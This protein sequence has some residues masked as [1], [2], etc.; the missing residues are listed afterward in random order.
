MGPEP[1]VDD[2]GCETDVAAAAADAADP[3]VMGRSRARLPFPCPACCS[4]S[5]S[6]ARVSNSETHLLLQFSIAA[7]LASMYASLLQLRIDHP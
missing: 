6:Y 4:K 2:T 1:T 5:R 7:S 3:I